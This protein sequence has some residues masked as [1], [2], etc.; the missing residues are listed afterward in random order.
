M[1]LFFLEW[2]LRTPFIVLMRSDT[3]SKGKELH[4]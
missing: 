3:R 1:L 4:L 2:D